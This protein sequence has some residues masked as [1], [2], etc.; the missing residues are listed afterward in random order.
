MEAIVG[1]DSVRLNRY[2]VTTAGVVSA[3][4]DGATEGGEVL[5]DRGSEREGE[6]KGEREKGESRSRDKHG[7]TVTVTRRTCRS[8]KSRNLSPEE[9]CWHQTQQAS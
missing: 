2:N 6:R 7:F 5:S 3:D 9:W 1:V 4:I 8:V